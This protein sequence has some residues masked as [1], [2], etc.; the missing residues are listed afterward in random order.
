MPVRGAELRSR[1][2]ASPRACWR[3]RC[4][5]WLAV[6]VVVACGGLLA[7]A[8]ARAQS[9]PVLAQELEYRAART[10]HEAALAALEAAQARAE[11]ATV[12]IAEARASGDGDRLHG[13]YQQAHA[14][15]SEV[16][17]QD[18]R[19]AETSQ[20][21]LRARRALKA[22]LE[23]SLEALTNQART[24]SGVRERTELA[25]LIRGRYNHLQEIEAELAESDRETFRFVAVPEIKVDPRDGPTEL[26]AKAELL[27]R[28]AAQADSAIAAIDRELGELA[29]RQRQEQAIRNFMSGIERFDEGVLP[30]GTPGRD[31][32]ER[33]DRGT[34]Q[35]PDAPGRAE[36]GDSVSMQP[37]VSTGERINQL[38]ALRRQV[39][40]YREEVLTRAEEFSRRAGGRRGE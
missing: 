2:W 34:T 33:A 36:A 30:L 38:R 27:A 1:P 31:A 37:A 15:W 18:R 16:T 23:E 3:A 39:E 5:C 11:R 29:Q 12:E 10:D 17:T 20:R 13:A 14:R 6:A 7:P 22:A 28:R 8:S 40:Q 21:L 25:A 9:D 19:A 24:T 35:G 32:T 26:R 4:G